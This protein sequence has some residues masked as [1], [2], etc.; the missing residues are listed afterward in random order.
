MPAA[1]D[2]HFSQSFRNGGSRLKQSGPEAVQIAPPSFP[3]PAHIS[4]L[5]FDVLPE[6]ALP[7]ARAQGYVF[8]ASCV[9]GFGTQRSCLSA[10]AG[11]MQGRSV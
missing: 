5:E 8:A 9:A 1:R 4:S 6:A 7:G 11:S 2:L 10:P 3:L